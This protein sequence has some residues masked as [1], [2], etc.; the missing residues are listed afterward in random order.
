MY[1]YSNNNNYNKRCFFSIWQKIAMEGTLL[2][3][4]GRLLYIEAADILK[5]LFL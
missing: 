5:D 3:T 2:I 4:T 1:Y